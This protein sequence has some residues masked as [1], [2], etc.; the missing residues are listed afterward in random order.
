M[1]AQLRLYQLYSPALPVGGFTYSQGIEWAV[2]AGWVVNKEDFRQWLL[3][4]LENN[5]TRLDL[6]VLLRLQQACAD[7]STGAETDADADAISAKADFQYWSQLLVASR[8]TK[9]LRLEERQRGAA[10]ARLLPALGV[11]IP[12]DLTKAVRSSQLAGLALAASQ[13]QIT[14]QQNCLGYAWSWLENN[15]TAGIKL[16][17]LGQTDGQQLML[18]IASRIPGAVDLA[19]DIKN[20]RIGSATPALAIASSQHEQQYTRL[21][22]S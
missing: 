6:P 12:A 13:W 18:D 11:E 3:S 21:F 15:I 4:L 19:A 2:E 5:L 14:P 9:E 17:P 20:A 7:A 10:L 22:R 16:I 8:E 1:L